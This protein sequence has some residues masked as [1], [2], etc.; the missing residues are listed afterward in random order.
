[1]SMLSLAA[2]LETT[3]EMKVSPLLETRDCAGM[4]SRRQALSGHPRTSVSERESESKEET[5]GGGLS[6]GGAAVSSC[7]VVPVGT[8]GGGGG[9]SF[10]GAAVSSC[11][12]V[13]VGTGER[14]AASFGGAGVSSC[15][16][17]KTGGGRAAPG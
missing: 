8:A 1:M 3:T 16:P 14:G 2:D 6:F 9:S 7:D 15:V 4:P 17:L 11:D 13:P 5:R 10:G 12:L